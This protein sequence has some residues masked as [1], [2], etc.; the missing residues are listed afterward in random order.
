MSEPRV[1]VVRQTRILTEKDPNFQKAIPFGRIPILARPSTTPEIS[2]QRIQQLFRYLAAGAHYYGQRLTT[3]PMEEFRVIT[4]GIAATVV[5]LVAI[6]VFASARISGD[7]DRASIAT[8]ARIIR[9][10]SRTR[11]L[12]VRSSESPAARSVSDLE[13]SW[14]MIP[15]GIP[16]SLPPRSGSEYTVVTTSDTAFQD[17]SDPLQF[18]DFKR[19]ETISIHGV[20]SGH[21]LTASRVAKWG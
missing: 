7:P 19:G 14:T 21:T 20:K 13:V 12:V 9:I 6:S 2:L 15:G 3:T 11:T 5:S 1:C 4:R 18:E 16:V 8:T 10:N 17:G